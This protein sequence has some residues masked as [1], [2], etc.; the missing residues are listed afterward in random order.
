L[1]M[2]HSSK[3]LDDMFCGSLEIVPTSVFGEAPRQWDGR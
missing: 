1:P 3:A 2:D